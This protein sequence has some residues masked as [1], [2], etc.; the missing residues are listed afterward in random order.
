MIYENSG[1]MFE[2][3]KNDF[4]KILVQ[5]IIKGIILFVNLIK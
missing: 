5:E 4:G 3:I 2:T 1:M